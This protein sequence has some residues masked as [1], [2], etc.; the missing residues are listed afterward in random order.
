MWICVVFRLNM[1]V[2]VCVLVVMSWLVLWMVSW[3]LF[4]VI[5]VV[6]GLIVLWL[7]CGV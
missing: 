5:V 1:L 7:W 6:C 4:Y 2:I 3:L